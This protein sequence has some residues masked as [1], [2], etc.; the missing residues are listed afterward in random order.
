MSKK[1]V[2]IGGGPA[3]ILAAGKASEL[4]KDVVLVEKNDRLGKKILISGK[5]RCNIT[6]NTDIEG[7]LENIPGNGNFLYSAFYTFSNTD[8]IELL[9]R[10]GLE[11]KVERGG[12]VFPVSDRA[13]DV[14]DT[15]ARYL[16]DA[17]V[18]V[19]LNSPV[20]EILV[21]NSEVNGV[22]FKD[23]NTI[24]CDSVVLCTGGV[25]YPGT[26]STGDGFKI[27]R[28]VGHEVVKLRPSLVPLI[29]SEKWIGELQG[30]SL[31]NV[32][33]TLINEKGKNIYSDFGE[34]LFTHYGVS[35][36]IILSSSRHILAYN[37]KGISLVIDLK[38]ALDEQKL[39]ERIRRDFEKFSRKQFKN[40][41]DEL[42]PQKLI[43]VVI[44][45]SQ[46]SPDKFVNQ[47]TKEERR[48]LVS[49]LKKFT[50]T[51]VG[52]RPIDEAIVTA[53]GISTNE[54]N[55]STMESKLIKGL[56]F[57]GE[58]IDV[59]AY[60]GGFNLTIAFSTGYLAGMNC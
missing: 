46:I 48:K 9:H 16:K 34:M 43:P 37:F 35:G 23:G 54:I 19:R 8:I 24:E 22:M 21:K 28:K 14:V 60:T 32:S 42:L 52:A 45:L 51:I 27:A 36:P 41:L 15:L 56:Y 49:I 25:S 20:S 38:P 47:I 55:P 5:G 17:G 4:G 11:T 26:G 1:V 18:K 50:L 33:V 31:K 39:D 10:Y 29:A 59:D 13:K 2:V 58:V 53:G 7:L 44:K 40:S 12:R 30:L 3:G 57:A 6:N